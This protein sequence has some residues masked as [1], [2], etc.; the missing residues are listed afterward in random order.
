M[1][2]SKTN[3]LGLI[4]VGLIG[5]LGLNAF[6]WYQNTQLKS[7]INSQKVNILDIEKINAE[8]EADYQTALGNLE[9][10][11]GNNQSLNEK[12]DQQIEELATQKSKINNLLYVKNSLGEAKAE[13]ESMKTQ[14]SIYVNEIRKLRDE[15]NQL[16][17]ENSGLIVSNKTLNEEKV[18]ATAQINSLDSEKKSLEQEKEIFTKENIELSGKVKIAKAIKINFIEVIGYAT[19]S[20]GKI[21]SKSRAKNVEFLRTCFKTETNVIADSGD[22]EFQ[23][24]IINPA[25]ETLYLEDSGSGELVNQL[26]GSPVR[27]TTSG[28][29][30][31]QNEDAEGC[32][33]FAPNFGFTKGNH[34]VELYNNG[35]MVGKGNFN[36][37]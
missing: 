7:Q 24:R 30:S 1:S 19:K 33:D 28:A 16:V 29:I 3:Y 23:I 25:G 26:D 27:Y 14:A 15:N 35:F 13:L 31:Y 11:R 6:Q 2:K 4:I 37:K 36:L 21:D 32:I 20:N 5:L 17:L 10:L 9:E 22:Q 18:Q 34:A 12:I 8:L